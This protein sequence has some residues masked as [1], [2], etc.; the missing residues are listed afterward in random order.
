[1]SITVIWVPHAVEP[2][3]QAFLSPTHRYVG[4]DRVY[5]TYVCDAAFTFGDLADR[6]T[7]I[8]GKTFSDVAEA[9]AWVENDDRE[10]RLLHA[11]KVVM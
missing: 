9:L 8:E 7:L 2:L 1:M 4:C 6:L 10:R 11:A 3:A 5:R